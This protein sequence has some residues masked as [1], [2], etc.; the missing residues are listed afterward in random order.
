MET[1]IRVSVIF[2][3]LLVALRI[4]GKRELGQLSPFDLLM[5]ML[6]PEI[7]SHGMIQDDFSIT[8]ALVG[9]STLLTLVMANSFLSHRFKG[10]RKLVEGEPVLLYHQGQFL[11]RSMN[12]E[13]IT[14]DEVMR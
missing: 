9:V 6:I 2:V 4:I 11:Q 13:R 5:I 12:L 14:P 7:V 1:V 10:F 3:F 8:N